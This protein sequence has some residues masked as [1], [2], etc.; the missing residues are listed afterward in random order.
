ME[1][2]KLWSCEAVD[3]VRRDT[4]YMEP[5]ASSDRA[6]ELTLPAKE[7]SPT[8]LLKEP[9]SSLKNEELLQKM[10]ISMYLSFIKSQHPPQLKL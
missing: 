6:R 3:A 5:A 9:R 2:W 10:D 7:K 8:Q 4:A 1:T